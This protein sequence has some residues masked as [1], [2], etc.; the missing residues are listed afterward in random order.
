MN[1]PLTPIPTRPDRTNWRE[2]ALCREYGVTRGDDP[3]WSDAKH[4]RAFAVAICRECPVRAACAAASSGEKVGVWAGVARGGFV[5]RPANPPRRGRC[6]GC[7][8]ATRSRGTP[9][10]CMPRTVLEARKDYCV[11]CWR[12]EKAA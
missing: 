10:A 5:G 12:K 9:A 4:E 1:H 8:R 11:R 2:E 3:W 6:T 7:G